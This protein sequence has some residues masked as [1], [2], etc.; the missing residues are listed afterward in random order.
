MKRPASH[1]KVTQGHVPKLR[2]YRKRNVDVIRSRLDQRHIASSVTCHSSLKCRERYRSRECPLLGR[3]CSPSWASL[4]HM[5]PRCKNKRT[6]WPQRSGW[7]TKSRYPDQ[8]RLIVWLRSS[9]HA[10]H[11]AIERAHTSEKRG[12]CVRM[13]WKKGCIAWENLQ[14]QS[15]HH[16]HDQKAR[17]AETT[18]LF[19]GLAFHPHCQTW[20]TAICR[21][22][23]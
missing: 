23:N 8:V 17:Q 7:N 4:F 12:E 9:S 21:P 5:F 1:T 14:Q 20:N 3:W 10:K 15:R 19:G 11:R 16:I 18:T 22:Q 13:K 6:W 2:A